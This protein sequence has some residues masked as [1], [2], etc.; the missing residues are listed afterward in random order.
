[1]P[2]PSQGETLPQTWTKGGSFSGSSAAGAVSAAAAVT[3]SAA[4]RAARASSTD[5]NFFIV[6][7]S[8]YCIGYPTGSGYVTSG[9]GQPRSEMLTSSRW[10]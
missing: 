7:S 3:H 6:I 9:L 8:L 5:S 4:D 10:R 1:M 2:S